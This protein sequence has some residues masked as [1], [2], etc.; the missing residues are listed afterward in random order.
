MRARP[1]RGLLPEESCQQMKAH[2]NEG[3]PG[4]GPRHPDG[5]LRHEW[6]QAY[7]GTV[8]CF[9]I[10]PACVRLMG[11]IFPQEE[12]HQF[13]L[14]CSSCHNTGGKTS[15]PKEH[16]ISSVLEARSQAQGS[17][18]ELFPSNAS[19]L[20][21]QTAIFS[22]CLHHGHP[23]CACLCPNLLFLERH[24]SDWIKLTPIISS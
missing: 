21:L 16:S 4:K 20:A 15:R 8:Y 22:L 10:F 13:V 11:D 24:H 9:F 6:L 7:E 3:K 18:Q 2:L 14:V 19:L 5:A 1:W 17:V 12:K 23:L